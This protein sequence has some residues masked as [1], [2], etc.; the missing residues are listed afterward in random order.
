MLKNLGRVIILLIVIG[1]V[2]TALVTIVNNSPVV[3][4]S[5][6]EEDRVDFLQATDRLISNLTNQPARINLP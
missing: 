4:N 6:Q 3:K 2:T 5:L 1:L